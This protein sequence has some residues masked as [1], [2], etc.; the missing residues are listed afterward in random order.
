[1]HIN[2]LL[3]LACNTRIILQLSRINGFH[4]IDH[5]ITWFRWAANFHSHLLCIIP[6]LVLGLVHGPERGIATA[7]FDNGMEEA[8]IKKHLL[9][10]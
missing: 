8:L 5:D 3:Y 4:A 7:F 2:H 10:E 6:G 1:M 9:G